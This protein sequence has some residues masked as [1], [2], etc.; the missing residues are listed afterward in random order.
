MKEREREREV[1]NVPFPIFVS[2][3]ALKGPEMI[4]FYMTR[5]LWSS[6]LLCSAANLK[7]RHKT[8]TEP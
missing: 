3:Q 4:P 7:E 8:E 5:V 6:F 2:S 1:Q